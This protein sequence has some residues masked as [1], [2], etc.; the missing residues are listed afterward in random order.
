MTGTASPFG[1]CDNVKSDV[2]CDK[3]NCD[4]VVS[5]YTD[6]SGKRVDKYGYEDCPSTCNKCKSGKKEKNKTKK[7]EQETKL[8]DKAPAKSNCKDKASESYCKNI[9]TQWWNQCNQIKRWK[10]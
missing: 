7:Q 5:W 4:S 8:E 6:G 1:D 2:E 10:M 9:I 3:V